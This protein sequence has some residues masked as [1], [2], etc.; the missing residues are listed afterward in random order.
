MSDDD[1]KKASDGVLKS[2]VQR[3]GPNAAAAGAELK[4]RGKD[5]PETGSKD[6]D[7]HPKNQGDGEG[8]AGGDKPEDDAGA[9]GDDKKDDDTTGTTGST[10]GSTG[11]TGSTGTTG[12]TGSTGTTGSTGSTINNEE[13]KN[14]SNSIRAIILEENTQSEYKNMHNCIGDIWTNKT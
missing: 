3:G 13:Y 10:G 4:K 1:I 5:V 12:S 7:D 14:L 9:T 11:S 6:P 8:T 2:W